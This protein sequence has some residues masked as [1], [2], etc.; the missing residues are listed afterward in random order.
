MGIIIAKIPKMN[1][2][3]LVQY[4]RIYVQTVKIRCNL[5]TKYKKVLNQINGLSLS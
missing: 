1:T 4:W 2:F 5:E 3:C